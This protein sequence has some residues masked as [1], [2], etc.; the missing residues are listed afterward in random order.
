M[1]WFVSYASLDGVYACP[2]DDESPKEIVEVRGVGTVKLQLPSDHPEGPRTVR[3]LKVLHIPD[4]KYGI[5]CNKRLEETERRKFTI[6]VEDPAYP[7][8]AVRD[9]DSNELSL[10]STGIPLCPSGPRLLFRCRICL[11]AA[12][13]V[14]GCLTTCSI[15]AKVGRNG[16]GSEKNTGMPSMKPTTAPR[17]FH[18]CASARPA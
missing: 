8:G 18:N 13:R 7:N 6:D 16:S 3:L 4:I 15:P 12:V 14:W 17:K 10:Y 11:D 2:E 1:S 5:I 9:K